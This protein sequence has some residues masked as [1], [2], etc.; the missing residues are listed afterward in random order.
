MVIG[1][2]SC[3]IGV[4]AYAYRDKLGICD[5]PLPVLKAKYEKPHSNYLQINGTAVH[6]C[7]EG[8]GPVIV[9][10]HG[11]MDSL[12]TWDGWV[13]E[14]GGCYRIVRMDL[15]GFGLTGPSAAGDYSK[16]AFVRFLDQFVTA[17]GISRFTL[18]G[19][20]LGGAIAWN[21][22]LQFPGK[23]EAMI[24]IDPAG[25]PMDIPYPLKIATIP[26]I[27]EFGTMMTPR[28]IFEMSL[29]QVLGDP[30]GITDDMVDR[31]YELSLRPGNREAL[32]AIM[33]ALAVLNEDP[34][35]SRRIAEIRVPT[36]LL[37]GEKDRWIPVAQAAQWRKD[38]PGIHSIVYPG[39]GHVPQMEIPVRSADDA[40]RW[41]IVQQSSQAGILSG[42]VLR[43]VALGLGLLL[44]ILAVGFLVRRYRNK[45]SF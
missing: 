22:A 19:N 30:R 38:L 12:H 34:A 6:Y 40:H 42:N 27:R 4:L 5:I 3:I 1:L 24:L 23:V 20:S 21:Y 17:L 11:I 25:Y 44:V 7:D 28:I 45:K 43:M 2:I 35:F 26:V 39:V 41:L 32:P 31:F 8:N 36:L 15:P 13:H 14:I 9:A 29:K 18:V 10:L 37:W 33:D 16:D